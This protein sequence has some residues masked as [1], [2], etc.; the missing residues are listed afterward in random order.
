MPATNQI[1]SRFI[2]K[3]IRGYDRVSQCSIALTTEASDTEQ[4][5]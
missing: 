1:A 5:S 4:T 3:L 2:A